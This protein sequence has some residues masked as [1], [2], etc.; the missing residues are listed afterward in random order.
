M[1]TNWPSPCCVRIRSI[2]AASRAASPDG[3]FAVLHFVRESRTDSSLLFNPNEVTVLDLD[4]PP[5]MAAG[6]PGRT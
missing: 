3:R 4:A 2:D 1:V 5:T 6:S